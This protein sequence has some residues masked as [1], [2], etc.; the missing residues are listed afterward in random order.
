MDIKEL[1]KQAFL[2]QD[3]IDM[4]ANIMNFAKEGSLRHADFILKV[5]TYEPKADNKGQLPLFNEPKI[6]L[7][8]LTNDEL[9]QLDSI[10]RKL[11]IS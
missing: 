11:G 5:I 2:E 9:K 10:Q 6:D 4:F 8:L 3:I 1:A 7:S